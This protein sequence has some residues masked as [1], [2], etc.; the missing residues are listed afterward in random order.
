MFS[1]C[2]KL[3]PTSLQTIN[4]LMEEIERREVKLNT[5]S[6]NAQLSALVHCGQIDKA[7]ELFTSESV[8]ESS[9]ETFGTL[10]LAAAKDRT[11]GI[12]RCVMIWNELVKRGFNLNLY[13]YNTLLLCLRDG[14]KCDDMI[15]SC[16]NVTMLSDMNGDNSESVC[17]TGDK[18]MC[19]VLSENGGIDWNVR[20]FILRGHVRYIETESLNNFL[21]S[22]NVNNVTP[23]IRTISI[24]S[25]IVPEF[26]EIIALSETIGVKLDKQVFKSASD[27]RKACGDKRTTKVQYQLQCMEPL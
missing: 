18:E 3:G 19:L 16:K 23:D 25:S 15:Q 11:N 2:S 20:V 12:E 13:C 10:L 26:G 22:M 17:V 1:A 21:N 24:L 14:G 6:F 4:K 8:P 7:F 27:F 5:Q 9:I